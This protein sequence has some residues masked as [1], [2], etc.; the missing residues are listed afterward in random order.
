MK[1]ICIAFLSLVLFGCIFSPTVYAQ[2]RYNPSIPAEKED[3]EKWDF[4]DDPSALLKKVYIEANEEN[5]KKV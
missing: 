4:S 1:K 2:Q 5:N 3:N